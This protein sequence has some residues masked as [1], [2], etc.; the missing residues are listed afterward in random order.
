MPLHVALLEPPSVSVLG[1][2][3]S[4]CADADASLHV[5]GTLPVA[6]T[7]PALLSAG[8]DDWDTLDWWVHPGW[9]DFRDAMSRERCIYFAVG[10]E[11]DTAEAPFRANSVLVVGTEDGTL[12]DRILEK[13]PTRIFKLPMPPRRRKVDLGHSVELL[14]QVAA[15]RV[16]AR[17]SDLPVLIDPMAKPLRYG[18]GRARR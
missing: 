8:P 18:R 9:R 6:R 12:P 16:A 5:V 7:D 17:A 2:V 4:R 14:L 1:A 10:A 11:R 15:E 3:A 13:Y